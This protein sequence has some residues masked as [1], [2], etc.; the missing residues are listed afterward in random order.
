MSSLRG[1]RVLSTRPAAQGQ[2][3]IAQLRSRG[4]IAVELPLFRI[5]PAGDPGRQRAQLC[6]ARGDS[7]WI[8]TSAN[9]ARYA[10]ALDAGPWPALLAIGAAT[11]GALAELGHPG[12][13]FP[14]A[15]SDSE[16]LLALPALR[17]PSGQR[18]LL[19]TG[20]GGRGLIE[21][22]LSARGA[23]VERVELYRRE[24]VDYGVDA[25][26]QAL[27]GID[28]L[29]CTSGESLDRLRVITPLRTWRSLLSRV[30]VVPSPRV[31]ELARRLGFTA[32]RA[33][34]QTSDEAL[35]ACLEQGLAESAHTPT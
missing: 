14:S 2:A 20:V 25:V 19:C 8:F 26:T 15:G 1:R 12:A 34:V 32:V 11:A 30:L 24:P 22:A 17:D 35:I 31:L 6:A 21:T 13:Q 28:A 27:Q 5:A 4:A 33:P 7:T 3:L 16:S 23:Q 29:V 9:A 18:F 10:A